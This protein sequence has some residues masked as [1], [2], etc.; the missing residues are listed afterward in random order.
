MID[1]STNQR[2]EDEKAIEELTQTNSHLHDQMNDLKRQYKD[3]I[4][5]SDH[6]SLKCDL[7]AFDSQIRLLQKEKLHLVK[8]FDTLSKE[9]DSS[10]LDFSK[11]K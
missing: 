7:N 4:D 10:I 11:S 9:R 8:M 3:F 1:D 6:A 2:E 5:P